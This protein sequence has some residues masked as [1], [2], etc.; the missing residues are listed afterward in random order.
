MLSAGR[1]DSNRP[2]ERDGNEG[3]C[4][5]AGKKSEESSKPK[6]IVDCPQIPPKDSM[7]HCVPDWDL[8][9]GIIPSSDFLPMARGNWDSLQH[10]RSD[11]EIMELIWE[12]GPVVKQS[13]TSRLI[14]RP[15]AAHL[16][17]TVQNDDAVLPGKPCAAGKDNTLESVVHDVTAADASSIQEDEMASWLHYPL[18]ESLEKEYC[19]DFFGGMPNTNVHM[20]RDTLGG[21]MSSVPAEKVSNDQVQKESP[22]INDNNFAPRTGAIASMT[23]TVNIVGAGKA[24]KESGLKLVSADKAMALGAGRASGILPQSGVDAFAKVRTTTQVPVSKW[25]TNVQPFSNSKDDQS[26]CKK[27]TAEVSV[28]SLTMPPPKMQ[29]TEV[30]PLKPVR[31]RLMNFSHFS[32]PA[33][34]MKAN[35]QS[36]TSARGLSAT[37]R[38]NRL[39]KVGSDGNASAEPS[40]MESTTSNMTTVGSNN[41]S[42]NHV[43]SFGYY[44]PHQIPLL[45]KDSDPATCSE[46]VIDSSTKAPEQVGCQNSNAKA[47]EQVGCQN[48]NTKAPGQVGCQNSNAKAADQVGCQISGVARS[49]APGG[50]E[51]YRDVVDVP[52]PTIT[53]SSG[54]SGNSAGRTEK[55]T[56]NSSKRKNR[57]VEESECQ[58]EDAEYESVDAK[59]QPPPRTTTAKRSRA[60][61]VHNQ[62]ERRR[63]DRINEKMRALQDLIPHC[64][65][66]DKASMLDEAIEYLKALQLQVQ[67][68]SM[69]GGMNV[70]PVVF[71]GGMQHFQMPQMAHLSP[72]GMGMGMGM[73]YS[74]GML[75]MG[76]A[77]GR[78]V[79]PLPSIHGSALPG[80]TIHCPAALPVSGMPGSGLSMPRLPVSGVT[81]S[82]FSGTTQSGLV[83]TSAPGSTDLQDQMQNENLMDSYK[84]YSSHP[85]MQFSPQAMNANLYNAPMLQQHQNRAQTSGRGVCNADTGSGN[86]H[87]SG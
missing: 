33:A 55:E 17:K 10:R 46:D 69:G 26:S 59:K 86:T 18:D 42:N 40:M 37:E 76:T 64:N 19:S 7:N 30:V 44:Q 63:R 3:L 27:T 29:A 43:P 87:T 70:H 38:C 79:M 41:G 57:D 23:N 2:V 77:S 74:I 82:V 32:R 13:Q 61:E 28:S 62:S 21:H 67:I 45:R 25:Y 9:D 73:G 16:S 5:V 47:P 1:F 14:K 22:L 66:S 68:M 71:P 11:D 78:P 12:N 75:D 51:K 72:M 56:S 39:A 84:F 65:K 35:L 49:L 48:P 52:E 4:R 31:S 6:D 34:T 15:L 50:I 85:Q 58:S 60:A 8:K 81:G 53:S 54:G 80:S 36:I 24:G 20:I 83:S